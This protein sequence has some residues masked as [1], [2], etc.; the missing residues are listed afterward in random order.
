MTVS[1][2]VAPLA[3]VALLA[4]VAGCGTADGPRPQTITDAAQRTIAQGSAHISIEQRTHVGDGAGRLT[5]TGRGAGVVDVAGRRAR[6]DVSLWQPGGPPPAIVFRQ[7]V[8]VDGVTLFRRAPW[9][10]PVRSWQKVELGLMDRLSSLDLE[11]LLQGAGKDAVQ[12]LRYLLMASGPVDR[13]GAE[14]VRGV[15]TTRY[16]VAVD[17]RSFLLAAPAPQRV[18]LRRALAKFGDVGHEPV[19]VW[20]D[21]DGLV[22]RIAFELGSRDGLMEMAQRI[23]LWQL[24]APVRIDVPAASYTPPA[25]RRSNYG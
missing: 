4:A 8:V 11:S 16:R 24:G 7:D 19:D 21:G 3:L 2:A 22:R 6:L 1:R 12:A 17:L 10:P 23:E 15:P 14:R 13:V 18:A 20:I 25:L 9:L 5:M